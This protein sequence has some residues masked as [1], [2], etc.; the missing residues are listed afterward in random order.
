MQSVVRIG[1]VR[2]TVATHITAGTLEGSY[3]IPGALDPM[4]LDSQSL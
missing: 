3:I 4:L 1:N 2:Y